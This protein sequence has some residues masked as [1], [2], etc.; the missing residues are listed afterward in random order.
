[1]QTRFHKIIKYITFFLLIISFPYFIQKLIGLV[2]TLMLVLNND[3]AEAQREAEIILSK[4]GYWV[5]IYTAF[6]LTLIAYIFINSIKL[7]LGMVLSFKREQKV[8]KENFEIVKSRTSVQRDFIKQM[9]ELR[10][11][12]ASDNNNA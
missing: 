12:D 10:N 1:M 6:F 5:Y 3:P 8:L 9:D 11:K 2:N 4:Y 7:F